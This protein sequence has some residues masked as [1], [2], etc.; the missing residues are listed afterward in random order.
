MEVESKI[1]INFQW[2]FLQNNHSKLES[3]LIH[4]C[5]IKFLFAV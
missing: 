4:V 1:K 3:G 5:E 2:P